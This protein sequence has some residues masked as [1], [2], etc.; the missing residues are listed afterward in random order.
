MLILCSALLSYCTDFYTD[1]EAAMYFRCCRL[2]AS[3]TSQYGI[4]KWIDFDEIQRYKHC[5]V[6]SLR[7][8]Q[9]YQFRLIPSSVLRISC[10]VEPVERLKNSRITEIIFEDDF[11]KNDSF[12]GLNMTPNAFLTSFTNV[13]LGFFCNRV[14]QRNEFHHGLTHLTVGFAFNKVIE[15]NVLPE[16]LTHLKFGFKFNSPFAERVL[17]QSLECLEFGVYFNQPF[18]KNVLPRSLKRLVFGTAF[19]RPLLQHTL[20]P[21]LTHLTSKEDCDQELSSGDALRCSQS[22]ISLLRK[23]VH[24]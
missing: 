11:T 21:C 22:N 1:Y 19:N 4:K 16:S 5:K 18:T 23:I 6:R 12:S 7:I 14:F 13:T 15:E 17:P 20:P 2:L 3:L 8:R 24:R 9:Q 10:V